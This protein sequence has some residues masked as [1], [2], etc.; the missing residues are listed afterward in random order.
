MIEITRRRESPCFYPEAF[1]RQ[2]IEEHL[3]TGMPKSWI[4]RKHG[5]RAKS[6]ILIWMRDLG[7]LP[8][9]DKKP[10]LPVKRPRILEKKP[11]DTGGTDDARQRIEQLE[12]QLQDERLRSE[13]YLRMIEIAETEYRVPIRKKPGTK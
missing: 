12:R 4:H 11:M 3:R 10:I 5:I 9:T 6:A 7:Y 8:G 2:V 1:K 13:M